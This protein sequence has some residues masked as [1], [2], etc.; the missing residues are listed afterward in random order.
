MSYQ[1]KR[2]ITTI[3]TGA[4]I[5]AA[6]CLYAF[7]PARLALITPDTLSPWAVTMLV[8]IGIGIGATIV[9]QI[10][11][12]ILFAISIAVKKKMQNM[13]ADDKEIE[14]NIQSEI[15]EDE[16]DKMIEL[17]SNK[18]GFG[19]AGF[20]FIAGL[21][22]LAFNYSPV[23]MLNILFISFSFGSLCEGFAQL[24]FYRRGR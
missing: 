23:I 13:Q 14:K 8:F 10:I 5:L 9:I 2:T 3:A 19:I 15:I 1:E 6:Y 18:V 21:L 24:Y 7:N 4:M 22:A 16:R 11:F 20:G 12:H 17:K